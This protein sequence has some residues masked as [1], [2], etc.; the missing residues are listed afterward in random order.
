MLREGALVP[1]SLGSDPGSSLYALGDLRAVTSLSSTC[2]CTSKMGTSVPMDSEGEQADTEEGQN[3]RCTC[4]WRVRWQVPSYWEGEMA[5][6]PLTG[7]VT[8]WPCQ[9]YLGAQPFLCLPS[10]VPTGAVDT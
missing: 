5:G 8:L 7:R 10:S 6:A 1:N 3:G 4:Y 2:F 9:L